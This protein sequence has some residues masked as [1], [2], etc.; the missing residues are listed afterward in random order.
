MKR[1]HFGDVAVFMCVFFVVYL[2][3]LLFVVVVNVVTEIVAVA[4]FGLMTT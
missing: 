2:L 1:P 3:L 4:G